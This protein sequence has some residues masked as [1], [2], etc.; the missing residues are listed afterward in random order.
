[1]ANDV[2]VDPRMY[3]SCG[4]VAARLHLVFPTH[5]ALLPAH[6]PYLPQ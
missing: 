1:M 4:T 3:A 6:L 2:E 5:F